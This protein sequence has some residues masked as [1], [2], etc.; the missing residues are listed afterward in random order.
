MKVVKHVVD[1]I[2]P[3]LA[4][5]HVPTISL[6]R[7]ARVT[8]MT[9]APV[10]VPTVRIAPVA[11]PDAFDLQLAAI[12][13]SGNIARNRARA[14]ADLGIDDSNSS[15]TTRPLPSTLTRLTHLSC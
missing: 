2:R 11:G 1:P 7:V 13:R 10:T 14:M 6:E 8:P 12:Q 4:L 9:I 3:Q 15:R 5:T